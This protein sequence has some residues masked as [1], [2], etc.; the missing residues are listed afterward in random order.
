MPIDHE[1][2]PGDCINSIALEHGFFPD[3]LWNHGSNSELKQKRKD[4]N[5]L[6]PGD[7]LHIPDIE[8]KEVS[9]ATEKRHRF[10]RKGVPAKLHLR[11]LKPKDVPP[12]EEE[13]A[14]G[15]EDD[16]ST[17]NEPDPAKAPAQE[18]E[19]IANAPYKLDI[20]GVVTEGQSDGD[21]QVKV[22]IPPNAANGIITFYPGKPEER[23]IPLS[24][25]GMDPVDTIIGARKRLDNLGYRCST[26]ENEVTPE[27]KDAVAGFQKD[28]DLDVNGELNDATKDKLKEKHGC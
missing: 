8:I 12:P 18:M 25:G 1:I 9:K 13:P 22:S 17:F 23:V 3:T 2:G 28:N 5:V 27:L 14:G 20:E 19:P 4:P 15:G 6:F 11:F 10:R 26:Q 7:K 21:G 24:L 16:C